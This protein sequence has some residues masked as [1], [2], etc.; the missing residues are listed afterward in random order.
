MVQVEWLPHATAG[1]QY[2]QQVEVGVPIKQN[3]GPIWS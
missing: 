1:N 3:M 2:S